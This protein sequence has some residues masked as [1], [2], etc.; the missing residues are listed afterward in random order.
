M[1]D[2][3]ARH[4]QEI[5][6]SMDAPTYEDLRAEHLEREENRVYYPSNDKY[7]VDGIS[8]MLLDCKPGTFDTL[9]YYRIVD[10]SGKADVNGIASTP[11]TEISRTP[12]I[13]YYQTPD[14]YERS[15]KQAV[16]VEEKSRWENTRS[17]MFGENIKMGNFNK[18]AYLEIRA[19]MKKD[20]QD[21]V[22]NKQLADENARLERLQV[23]KEKQDKEREKAELREWAYQENRRLN[24]Q[25]KKDE[26]REA[27]LIRNR[28]RAKAAKERRQNKAKK[29]IEEENMLA[30][31]RAIKQARRKRRQEKRRVLNV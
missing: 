22:E 19:D 24:K 2:D 4:E 12:N 5:M 14:A 21:E 6:E 1:A 31:K 15:Q 10:T 18:E 25:R 28:K 13:I 7:I 11:H 17:R 29:K 20:K 16:S 3:A 8:G 9:R 26:R 30:S 23:I 27:L